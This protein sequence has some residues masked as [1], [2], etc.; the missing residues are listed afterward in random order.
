MFYQSLNFAFFLLT[1]RQARRKLKASIAI[2]PLPSISALKL[3]P[4]ISYSIGQFIDKG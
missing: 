4:F 2:S 3:I 1:V